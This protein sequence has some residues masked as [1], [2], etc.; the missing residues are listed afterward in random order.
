MELSF[1]RGVVLVGTIA[2]AAGPSLS[3]RFT[4]GWLRWRGRSRADSC[5]LRAARLLTLLGIIGP[6][7]VAPAT[8]GLIGGVWESGSLP[9]AQVI[10]LV[11]TI[12]L[13]V[14][15]WAAFSRGPAPFP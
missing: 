1:Q 10:M 2:V 12:G 3:G 11:V 6:V 4:G 15:G 13:T 14:S 7:L 5:G 8:A 9:A